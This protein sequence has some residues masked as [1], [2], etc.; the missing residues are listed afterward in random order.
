M[1]DK[2]L[3]DINAIMEP[4][5]EKF[6]VPQASA[7][8]HNTPLPKEKQ[9]EFVSWV[10]DQKSKGKDPFR[11]MEDYDVYGYFLSGAATDDRGHGTD[12]F[13]KPNHPTFSDESMYH[14]KAGMGGKWSEIGGKT[15][16]FASPDNLKYRTEK[17][18]Q[19]YFAENEPGVMLVLPNKKKNK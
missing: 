10:A 11:D 17:E 8:E 16:F 2:E 13:K 6:A 15:Y 19:K 12:K 18:L 3:S 14:G 5:Q 4:L 7:Y 1:P 9:G